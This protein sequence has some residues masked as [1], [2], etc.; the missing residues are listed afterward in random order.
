MLVWMIIL[1]SSLSA[2]YA[3]NAVQLLRKSASALGM[4]R[5]VSVSYESSFFDNRGRGISSSKGRLDVLG[6]KFRLQDAVTAV[7][8]G[9]SLTFYN[10]EDNT[11]NISSPTSEELAQINPLVLLDQ[12][13]GGFHVFD[14]PETKLGPVIGLT[15]KQKSNFS[16]IEVCLNREN[17]LP[18]YI[19]VSLTDRSYISIKIMGVVP[20]PSLAKYSFKIDPKDYPKAE[21]IDLR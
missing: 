7:Y 10:K 11:L 14:L 2:A 15:P 3:Q 9:K 20:M 19:K 18:L 17:N 4:N 5:G 1:F 12:P 21:I 8:D 16:Q 13:D 6:K